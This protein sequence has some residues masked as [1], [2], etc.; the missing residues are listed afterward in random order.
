MSSVN[1]DR[2]AERDWQSVTDFI[3]AWLAARPVAM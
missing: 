3:L 1:Y 2:M